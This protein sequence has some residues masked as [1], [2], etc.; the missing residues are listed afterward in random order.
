MRICMVSNG[1]AFDNKN[2][3]GTVANL[4][5]RFVD[6]G[7]EV[8][9]LNLRH[10]IPHPVYRGVKRVIG[11][12]IY[13][14][15][16]PRDPLLFR[17]DFKR[18]QNAMNEID[19]DIYLFCA[20]YCV[21]SKKNKARYYSYVD[22][23]LR[24]LL[25]ADTFKLVGTNMFLSTYEKNEK[26]C[27]KR[28]DGV[29]TMNEWSKNSI[30]ELYQYPLNKIKNVG[31]GINVSFY[32]GNKNYERPELLIV[33]RKGTEHLK[34]LDLLLDGFQKAK[35]KIPNLH[36]SVVGTDYKEVDGVTYYYNK[37]REITVELFKKSTLYVMPAIREPNG[38][39]YLE[40]LASKTPI[41][42]L[43]RFAFP[44]F[45]GYGKYGFVVENDD[46]NLVCEV[47]CKA[48]DDPYRLRKMGEE[49][50]KFVRNRYSWDC[51]AQLMMSEF[52]GGDKKCN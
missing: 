26:I 52:V 5:S 23:T 1:D 32:D 6:M 34:G 11:R 41:I 25:E 31:F 9:S 20:E 4:S 19:A 35:K 10:L 51:I 18:I 22:A 48:L 28:L 15:G 14:K 24:P 12:Y 7:V 13:I 27:Y 2:W 21:G 46:S 29:F 3:S 40:A 43:D 8:V 39:T 37:P 42:G 44:E 33:L 38:I 30:N 36:L 16:S 49:G 50:Q 45:S 17:Y 47:I